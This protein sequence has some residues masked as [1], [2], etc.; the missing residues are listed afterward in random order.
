LNSIDHP[1]KISRP[2][3]VLIGPTAIGKTELSLKLAETFNCEIISMDSM[4]VYRYMDIGTAKIKVEERRAI[5]HHL[6]DIRDPDEQYDAVCFARDCLQTI[7][8]IHNRLKIPLITGGTGLYLRSLKEGFFTGAPNDPDI[9][10]MLQARLENDGVGTLHEEL[11]LCDCNSAKI[12]HPNDTSRILR[13]L[14]VF[15][16]TGVPLSTHQ[17]QQT[18]VA[19]VFTNMLTLGLT[20]DRAELYERINLRSAAMLKSGLEEEVGD[21][22]GR[23]YSPELKSMQSIGYRHMVQRIAGRWSAEELITYLARD[24][25]RYAKRQYTWFNRDPSIR[26]FNRDDNA[27]IMPVVG[28]WFE[29]ISGEEGA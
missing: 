9:R 20:C 25:R 18:R 3:L 1:E 14:E 2:I 17:E 10:A 21:L 13:A 4:Q 22:L 12:I 11:F 29:A 16:S 28:K 15:L 8:E 7:N 19:P 24:T 6:L 23:G 5:P 27:S 26:W